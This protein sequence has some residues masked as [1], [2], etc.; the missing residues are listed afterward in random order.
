VVLSRPTW[1]ERVSIAVIAIIAIVTVVTLF[2]DSALSAIL[3]GLA[4]LI[5]LS[6]VYQ[7]K[8]STSE[9]RTQFLGWIAFV[10]I[11]FVQLAGI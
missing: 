1:G 6:L 11:A 10:Q 8:A 3:A 5:G 4:P 2:R 9:K 7:D